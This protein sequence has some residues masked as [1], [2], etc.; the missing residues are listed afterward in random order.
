LRK[1]DIARQPLGLVAITSVTI[2]VLAAVRYVASPVAQPSAVMPVG[3]CLEGLLPGKSGV[4]P[5]VLLI[6]FNALMLTRIS[7]HNMLYITK[8]YIPAVV[9]V[10]VC[11]GV[12]FNQE[13]LAA[14]VASFFIVTG[15]GV[16]IPGF[17]HGASF[18]RCFRGAVL[19]GCAVLF[20]APAALMVVALPLILAIFLRSGRELIVALVGFLLP[21]AASAYI[22]WGMG[23]SGGYLFE[24]LVDAMVA[25][26]AT[27]T[28]YTDPAF[29]TTASLTVLVLFLSIGTYVASVNKMRTRP[30]RIVMT[31][32]ILF[33]VLAAGLAFPARSVSVV[34]MLAVPMAIILP[35]YFA[36]YTGIAPL[37]IYL[38]WIF[39]VIALNLN[40]F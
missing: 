39:S 14:V 16:I 18:D 4:V 40:G 29:L 22:F 28:R 6:I 35:L 3:A 27:A 34:N 9:Y 25:P 10:A 20:Y 19:V 11:C 26:P 13:S 1:I 36:R 5:L 21:T 30:Y 38:T 24:S 2:I 17:H 32:L 33:V 7:T 12:F 15:L 23:H 37:V 31:F 8:S